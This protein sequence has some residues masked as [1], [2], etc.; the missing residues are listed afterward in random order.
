[1]GVRPLVSEYETALAAGAAICVQETASLDR[2]TWNP[3]SFPELSVQARSIRFREMGVALNADGGAGTAAGVGVGGVV[4]V[5]VGGTGVEVGVGVLVGVAVGWIGVKVAVAG[6][7][8][9]VGVG[10]LVAVAVGGTGVKVAVGGTGVEGG[11]GVLVGVAV[12]GTGVKVAVGGTG[13]EVGDGVLVGVA[14]G[15]KGVEVR[16]G[17]RVA[18]GGG[19]DPFTIVNESSTAPVSRRNFASRRFPFRSRTIEPSWFNEM[20]IAGWFREPPL[21]WPELPATA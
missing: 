9:E 7:G 13:V 11:D 3:V 1:L 17:V 14:V 20:N 18:V 5:A 8:V 16:V 19:A 6:T 21:V 10:V 2:S 4:G 15:G 12:G